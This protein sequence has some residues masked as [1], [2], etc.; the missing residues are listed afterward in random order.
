MSDPTRQRFRT[1]T[2][3]PALIG[4]LALLIVVVVLTRGSSGDSSEPTSVSTVLGPGGSTQTGPGSSE[5]GSSD[6]P[7]DAPA[8]TP[9]MPVDVTVSDTEQIPSGTTV[10]I[11]AEP[12]GQS[13]TYGVDARLCRGDVAILD[14]GTFTPTMGGVCTPVP[15]APD[16]DALIRKVGSPPYQGIDLEFRVGAG[17]NTFLTQYNGE[18]TV[19]C[20]PSDPCQIVL[21]LQYPNGFGFRGIPVTFS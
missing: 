16:T 8:T 17:S 19:T 14:D 18:V 7:A 21:K 11:R 5:P 3:V 12:E 20:G 6:A 9:D 1:A 10:S 4:I 15:L 13:E 2:V